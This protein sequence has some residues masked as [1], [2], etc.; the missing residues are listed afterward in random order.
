MKPA[1]EDLSSVNVRFSS[2]RKS[3]DTSKK[4][5]EQFTA[6]FILSIH[7]LKSKEKIK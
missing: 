3:M 1:S 6:L 4:R 5:D 7:I 2:A